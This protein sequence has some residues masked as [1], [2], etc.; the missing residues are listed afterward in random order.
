MNVQNNAGWEVVPQE[1]QMTGLTTRALP[2]HIS[3]IFGI[4]K[5]DVKFQT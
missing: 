5:R 1:G 3:S 2:M 4:E